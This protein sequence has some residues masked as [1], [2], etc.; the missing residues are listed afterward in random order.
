MTTEEALVELGQKASCLGVGMMGS[1]ITM[2][3]NGQ[4][5]E[6]NV[7]LLNNLPLVPASYVVTF[8]GVM[9]IVVSAVGVYGGYQKNR[10]YLTMFL[11]FN[12]SVFLTHHNMQ[13][14]LK[15]I[16]A[17]IFVL[18]LV[19]SIYI[20]TYDDDNTLDTVV[21][22]FWFEEGIDARQRRIAY[23]NYFDCCGWVSNTDS[24][25][26]GYSTPCTRGGPSACREATQKWLGENFTPTALF[27]VVF[28]RSR[29]AVAADISVYT[30]RRGRGRVAALVDS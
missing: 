15:V 1:G 9:I 2:L 29:S 23:Q 4:D 7:E 20:L 17:G 22:D 30:K 27:G 3:G 16:H 18:L 21:K 19:N 12:L 11:F 25:A 6:D 8:L 13:Q 5:V 28:A 26:S 10:F 14:T 24:L